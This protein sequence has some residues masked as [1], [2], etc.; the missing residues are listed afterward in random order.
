M[1]TPNSRFRCLGRLLRTSL[2]VTIWCVLAGF[3]TGPATAAPPDRC[4]AELTPGR[5]NVRQVA[6]I[7]NS[8]TVRW[9]TGNEAGREVAVIFNGS[10]YGTSDSG[11]LAERSR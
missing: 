10:S 8:L 7:G 2:L 9:V 11:D 3:P 4:S 5:I 1:N 6:D